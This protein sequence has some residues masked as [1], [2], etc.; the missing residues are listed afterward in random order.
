MNQMELTG[1]YAEMGQLQGQSIRSMGLRFPTPDPRLV[2]LAQACRPLLGRHAPELLEEISS[3]AASA[4]D[5]DLALTTLMLTAPFAQTLPACSIVAVTPQHS[6]DGKMW[7]GRNYDFT[8]EPAKRSAT[9]YRTYP[10]GGFASL[11][12]SD[13]WVGRSDGLN[14]AGLFIGLTAT[15]QPGVQP[16]LAFWFI[17]RMVL[18]RCKSV[19]EAL[20]ILSSVPHAQSR[21]YLLADR[22]GRAVVVEAALDGVQVREPEDGI[23]VTTN[24]NECPALKGREMFVP[25]DSPVR[26]HRLRAL[27]GKA[28]VTP[29]DIKAALGDR[30]ALVCAHGEVFGQ[31]YGTIWSLLGSLDE[32]QLEIAE[33][34]PSGSMNYQVVKF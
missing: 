8:Y 14:E 27:A 9:T 20:Q 5:D 4:G 16:G 2:E 7:V 6:S 10:Q 29:A 23:L 17:V 30:E 21:N 15:F 19:D 18:D 3:L 11:G 34:V 26:Y 32:R 1:T 24:H 12:N 25:P 33:G 22:G 13:I 28:A 31:A